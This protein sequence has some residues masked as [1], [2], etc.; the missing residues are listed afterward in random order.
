MMSD[1]YLRRLCVVPR[2][3]VAGGDFWMYR[4][5]WGHI[6]VTTKLTARSYGS[7]YCSSTDE[8]LVEILRCHRMSQNSL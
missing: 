3:R 6:S 7:Y 1:E 5:S 8:Q 2:A 4:R